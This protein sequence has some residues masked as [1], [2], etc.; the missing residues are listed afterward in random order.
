MTMKLEQ[1]PERKE[2]LEKIPTVTIAPE[3]PEG[4]DP[5]LKYIFAEV[6]DKDGNAKNVV[7]APF[8]G[9][10]QHIDIVK[11]LEKELAGQPLTV[12]IMG[13][14][15]ISIDG[16]NKLIKIHGQ[17]VFFGMADHRKAAQ[18]V[19]SSFPDFH[20]SADSSTPSGS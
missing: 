7:R 15:L 4:D 17:S 10:C 20:V 14:G 11:S 1:L 16:K 9:E 12:K 3:G 13:G 5:N 2:G 6:K 18:L 8:V 19:E